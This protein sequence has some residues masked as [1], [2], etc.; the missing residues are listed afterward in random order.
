METV[1]KIISEVLGFIGVALN[2]A[3]YQQKKRNRLLIIKLVSDVVWTLHYGLMGNYSGAAVTTIGIARESTFLA[4]DKKG[5]DRRP[6]LLVFFACACISVWFTWGGWFSVLPATASFLSVISFWQQ[7][8]R[9][10]RLLALPISACMLTYSIS[11]GSMAGIANEV[12][13]VSSTVIG[14]V[15]HDIKRRKEL[16]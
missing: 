16:N 5:I 12:F 15:R 3:V 7:K 13:T 8:P 2:M 1:E 6:F 11:V 10:S 4:I 14:I 9:V